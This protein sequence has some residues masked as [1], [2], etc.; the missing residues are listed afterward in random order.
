MNTV[1][2][3]SFNNVLTLLPLNIK[4]YIFT[5]PEQTK[6]S[7]KEIRLRAEKP[8]V[9]V[10]EKGSSFLTANSKTTYIYSS[11]LPKVSLKDLTEI[12]K[13]AC[14][15]SVYSHQEDINSG[16]LTVKGGHRIGLCGT[17]VIE[18]GKIVSVRDINCVNIRIAS[19][20][21]GCAN[22][23]V[24]NVFFPGLKN[25]VIA[26]PPMCGKTTVLRDLARQLSDGE[27]GNY[28]K[29]VIADER[30]EIA[31]VT[32]GICGCNVG[33]NT[34][35]LSA[36]SKLDAINIAL[37]TM[38]PDIVFCDEIANANEVKAII[39]GIM[40]GVK[41]VVT[42][43][44][45]DFEELRT[46]PAGKLLFDSGLFDCCIMLGTKERIGKI[47]KIISIKS[48]KNE[49]SRSDNYGNNYSFNGELL[50]RAN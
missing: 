47:E 27:T 41:F 12:V 49:K 22:E 40:C 17:A 43:H 4:N 20:K 8:I 10:T 24:K 46:R 7:I 15:Y 37:R 38:S 30:N 5:L 29:C 36:Y 21:F 26:G 2:L 45:G 39:N 19:Q 35:V 50:S 31:C 9:I 13:R 32:N 44:C 11:S 33:N 14:D 25:T 48:D 23:I 6:L 16:F 3:N 34:D 18:K 42:A 28:Y 1:Q